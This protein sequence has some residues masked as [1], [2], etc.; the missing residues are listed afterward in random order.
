MVLL[1]LT[2]VFVMVI[3]HLEARQ[4]NTGDLS[5]V[6]YFTQVCACP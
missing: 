2:L 5:V 4:N 6:L 1:L 3:Y